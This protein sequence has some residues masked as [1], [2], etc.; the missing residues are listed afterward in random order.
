[1]VPTFF[2]GHPVYVYIS[3]YISYKEVKLILRVTI[4]LLYEFRDMRNAYI[5]R[6]C[7]GHLDP[8]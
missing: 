3:I 5:V 6:V 1:M 4:K 2:N 7:L 8:R